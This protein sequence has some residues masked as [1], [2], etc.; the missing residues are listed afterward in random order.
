[1][2]LLISN[3]VGYPVPGVQSVWHES[4]SAD[5]EWIKRQAVG[6][7]CYDLLCFFPNPYRFALL[8][9]LTPLFPFWPPQT[10][11]MEQPRCRVNILKRCG[12]YTRTI[13]IGRRTMRV[14][15]FMSKTDACWCRDNMLTIWTF[16]ISLNRPF[17]SINCYWLLLIIIDFID[18]WVSLF[19]MP[20]IKNRTIILELCT[21]HPEYF[22][23][24]FHLSFSSSVCLS[25]YHWLYVIFLTLFSLLTDF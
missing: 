19:D 11:S 20:T 16:C 24:Y 6:A 10:K 8:T 23:I 2:F 7:T 1:M 22:H 3:G 4:V 21:E 14:N 18:Y 5:N 13:Y 9:F 17:Q 15:S 12:K 25:V